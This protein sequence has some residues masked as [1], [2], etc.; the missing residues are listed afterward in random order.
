MRLPEKAIDILV[1]NLTSKI[2]KLD[3]FD[4]S[5][6][7]DNH[8]KTLV[9]RCNKITELNL[10]GWTSITKKSLNFIIEHLQLTLVQLNYEYSE[11]R[12]DLSDLFELKTMKKLE[13]LCYQ[14]L[15][16]DDH[17]RMKNLM[18]NLQISSEFGVNTRIA[19]VCD[20]KYIGNDEGFWIFNPEREEQGFWE[21]KA[22]R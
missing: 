8:I 13:L 17:I 18:P 21:I 2:E 19:G 5:D 6:L 7:G 4:L 16:C 3:L 22:E 20:Y 10:G 12:F 15:C 11:V 1:S 14:H 9:T